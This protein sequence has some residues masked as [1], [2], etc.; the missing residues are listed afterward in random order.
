MADGKNKA[1][2]ERLVALVMLAFGNVKDVGRFIETGDVGGPAKQSAPALT[3]EVAR[4]M[5]AIETAG[6]FVM[7]DEVDRI[8]NDGPTKTTNATTE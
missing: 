1:W 6:R 4:H 2:R 5:K 8:L 3:P 7:P